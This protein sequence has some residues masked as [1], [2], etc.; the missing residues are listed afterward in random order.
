MRARRGREHL[1]A[2]SREARAALRLSFGEM[3]QGCENRTPPHALLTLH[4]IGY[5]HKLRCRECSEFVCAT[6]EIRTQTRA[7]MYGVVQMHAGI[8]RAP[9]SSRNSTNS[10]PNLLV[11]LLVGFS[12]S[13]RSPVLRNTPVANHGSGDGASNWAAGSY[14]PSGNC[15]LRGASGETNGGAP[16]A[17][18]WVL[19][20]LHMSFGQM[21]FY[22]GLLNTIKK[23]L[24]R[25]LSEN[26]FKSKGILIVA[27]FTFSCM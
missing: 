11:H 6:A 10:G 4:L 14:A 9:N 18:D 3:I 19:L 15:S 24:V 20:M 13:Q 21:T 5:A 26:D 12:V 7:H 27:T 22:H 2:R 17:G 1:T 25:A 23:S 16:E 8:A